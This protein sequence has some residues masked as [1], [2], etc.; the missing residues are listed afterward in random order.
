MSDP[1]GYLLETIVHPKFD[2]IILVVAIVGLVLCI[3]DIITN[4][5]NNKKLQRIFF[6]IQEK[7]KKFIEI[8]KIKAV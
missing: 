8:R 3:L 5:F 7:I 6:D 4:F 2:V 1:I